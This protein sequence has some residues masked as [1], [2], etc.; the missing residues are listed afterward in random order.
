MNFL[1]LAQRAAVE[2]GVAATQSMTAVLS[3]TANAAGSLGRI[4]NWVADAWLDLQMEHDDW[5][6]MRSS[7]VLGAGASFVPALGVA[8]TPLGTGAGQIGV[9]VDSFGKWDRNTFRNYT[10]AVGTQTEVFLDEIPFDVWRDSY[11]L[12]ALRSTKSRPTAIA[13][14]PDQ[15]LNVGPPSDGNYTVTAD[16]FLAP[17]PL[18]NDA[19]IPLGLPTRFHMLIVYRTMIKYAGY[20][21]AGE[22]YQRGTTEYGAM[23]ARL[24]RLR[25]T[26]LTMGGALA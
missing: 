6:W 19:D 7:N 11:M 1:T 22:V 5:D 17:S 14:G 21:S 8:S 3:T 15:S 25:L 23:F 20:E 12:G 24:E 4:V 13:V 10:T 2:C 26:E 18:L 9:A 16:Y